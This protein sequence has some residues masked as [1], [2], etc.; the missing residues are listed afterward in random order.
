LIL[1]AG[2]SILTSALPPG[3]NKLPKNTMGVDNGGM[4]SFSG[5]KARGWHRRI[6]SPHKALTF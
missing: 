3:G 2:S 4:V 6:P 5:N 1:G